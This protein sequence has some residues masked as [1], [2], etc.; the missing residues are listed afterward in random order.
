[1]RFVAALVP[2][3]VA[4][5]IASTA[6]GSSSSG[7]AAPQTAATS[8]AVTAAT[9]TPAAAQT[10][11]SESYDFRVVLT[12]DWSAADALVDWDGGAW[13]GIDAPTFA[14]FTNASTG[15]TLLVAAARAPKGTT[16]TEWR[17]AMVQDAPQICVQSESAD[18]T[19]LDGEPALEWTSACGDGY[20][21]IRLA[22]LHGK[23]GYIVLLP[24]ATDNDD[25]EDQRVFESIRRSFRFTG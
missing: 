11:T 13:T 17:A 3:A 18:E 7:S 24:S 25:A 9:T 19:T 2:A 10:F 14:R 20:D 8:T 21:V 16:L 4:V 6:C 22:T 1:V 5:V 12:E 15:R 23:R